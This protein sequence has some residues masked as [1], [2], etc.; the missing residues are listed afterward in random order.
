VP[1]TF[2]EDL[3][4]HAFDDPHEYPVATA[5]QKAVEVYQRLVVRLPHTTLPIQYLSQN[6]GERSR[7]P[8]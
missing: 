7:R 3:P 5:S 1:S 2:Q 8:S 4:I 6:V